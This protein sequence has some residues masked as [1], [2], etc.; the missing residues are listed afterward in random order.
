MLELLRDAALRA[1]L[2]AAG[3]HLIADEYSAE[4]MAADYLCVYEEAVV[5]ERAK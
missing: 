4:R 3:R 2:G 1:R 5:Q